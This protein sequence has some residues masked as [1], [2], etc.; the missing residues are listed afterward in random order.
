MN[1]IRHLLVSLVVL[2]GGPLLAIN[3]PEFKD[4]VL[5]TC[6]TVLGVWFGTRAKLAD[7]N[8]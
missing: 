7:P 8:E 6:T 3:H 2:V 4:F 5:A 1:D